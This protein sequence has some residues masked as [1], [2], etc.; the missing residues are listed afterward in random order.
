M[1]EE[2]KK[3]GK[4]GFASFSPERLKEVAQKGG[5][6][7]HELGRAH[8]FTEEEAKAAGRRGGMELSRKF[9]KGYMSKIG[10]AGVQKRI[11]LRTPGLTE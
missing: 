1:S 8:E 5:K 7:A 2:V 6:K 11:A 9:G 3:K 10:K 4:Q